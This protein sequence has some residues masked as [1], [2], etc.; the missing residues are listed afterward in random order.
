MAYFVGSLRKRALTSHMT[1]ME[2]TPNATKAQ[3]K[4]QC[5]LFFKTPYEKH[6]ATKKLKTIAQKLT[7]TVQ[8]YDKRFKYL[9]IQLEYNI[10]KQ[11]LI[12]W[13]LAGLLQ[14]I[15][16]HIQLDNFNTYEDAL[17]KALQI[18]MDKDYPVKT[19]DRRIDEKL[20]T[21]QKSMRKMNLRGNDVQCAKCSTTSHTKDYC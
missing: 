16:M 14:K 8:E 17:T 9:L 3:I 20:E 12:Q 19:I 21:L 11:L 13:F 1:Y 4:Q 2:K 10:D 15:R 18:E 5:M 7:E 6:L